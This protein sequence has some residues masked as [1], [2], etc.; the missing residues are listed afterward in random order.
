MVC[1]YDGT[2]LV[3][4]HGFEIGFTVGPIFGPV[5]GT[6][7]GIWDGWWLGSELGFTL[8]INDERWVEHLAMLTLLSAL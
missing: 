8:G 5:D 3:T 7:V 2:K 1:S 6:G 4:N